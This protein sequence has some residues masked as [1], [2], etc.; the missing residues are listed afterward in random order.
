MSAPDSP[1]LRKLE[2][3]VKRIPPLSGTSTR[4]VERLLNLLI[5][6]LVSRTYVT[7][8]RLR[9][10]VEQ[11]QQQLMADLFLVTDRRGKML[12]RL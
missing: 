5:T 8:E 10:V 12:V 2:E 1:A 7:K 3:L 6:L 11:Y 4:Q 9:G